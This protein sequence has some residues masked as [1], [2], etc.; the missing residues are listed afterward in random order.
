MKARKLAAP[1]M[2]LGLVVSVA[3]AGNENI[4]R[5]VLI[6]GG[7]VADSSARVSPWINV[8]GAHRIVI[9]SWSV[10]TAAWTTADSQYTDSISTWQTEF[11]DSV[12]FIGR[13]SS[14]TLV[15]ARSGMSNANAFPVCADSVMYSGNV[16]DTTTKLVMISHPPINKI[17]RPAVNG[18][19]VYGPVIT[20]TGPTSVGTYG[21]G[22]INAQYMRVRITPFTRSTLGGVLSTQ[23]IRTKGINGLRVEALVI[24]KNQ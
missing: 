11:S 7:N 14:G 9:R 13:D 1:L 6:A 18:S 21:D 22:S 10:N 24:F 5:V 8:R 19:G 3:L 2:L 4:K 17:L 20:S 12:S 23:G 15:T 16:Q